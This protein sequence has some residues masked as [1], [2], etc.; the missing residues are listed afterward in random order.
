MNADPAAARRHLQ[1]AELEAGQAP[2]VAPRPVERIGVVGAGTM[3][4]GIAAVFLAAGFDVTLVERSQE[5]LE[6]GLAR[7]TDIQDRAVGKGRIDR[8]EADRRLAALTSATDQSV[9]R[10]RDLVLEAVFEDMAVKQELLARLGELVKPGAILASNTSYLN[11]D[12]LARASGR[13]ADVV[14]LHF[15]SPAHVM[16]LLEVVRGEA[17]AP[18][19][20]ATAVDL[21]RRCGKLPVIARV[22]DG[23]IGNRIYNAYRTQCEFMVEEGALPEQVDAALREFGFAMGPFAVWDM[24][25]LD[26]ALANRERLAPTRDPRER[27]PEVLQR[28]CAAGR[29]GRKTGAGWYRYPEGQRHGE[30]DPEVHGTIRQVSREL[31]L[32]RRSFTDEQI[33]RRAL[34]TIVNEAKLIL[35]EGIAER[36]SDIDLVLVN[37]YGF[38]PDLGGPLYWARDHEAEV[39]AGIADA[40]RATGFGF[41]RAA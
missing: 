9:L 7:I 33:V 30:P 37:G 6:R 24:S 29:L 36:A 17:T 12:E 18:D 16:R 2:D 40:E 13:D 41:R 26:I 14:G 27:V 10:D 3:G 35:A 34:G 5:A 19:T 4:A 31:G 39:R 21:A 1:Q 11:L 28:L 20:L 8:A 22:C 23:F 15:F 32:V 38:P 25:G